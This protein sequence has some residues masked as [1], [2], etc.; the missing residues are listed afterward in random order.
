MRYEKA[1]DQILP[2]LKGINSVVAIFLKG[3]IARDE[4]DEYSDLDLY[5]ML[6]KGIQIEEVYDEVIH[7]LENYQ[8]LLF[9]ELVEIICPQIVGVF[10]DMLH[11]DCY[12]VHEDDYPKTDDIK[13]LYDPNDIL[14]DYK[15]EDLALTPAMFNEVA[16]DSCWFIYQ[17]DHIVKRGQHLWTCQMIDK[18][19]IDTIK[20]LLYRYYPQKAV[21]GKKA[22]HH[23][24][25]GIYYE[26]IAINDLNNSKD[27][28][29]AVSKFMN[30]YRDYVVEIVEEQWVDGFE[31]VYLYLLKKYA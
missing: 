4:N 19:L 27:H 24:P 30:L 10:E 23:L 8:K 21:L 18:A 7:S 26:L 31:K 25:S 11:I 9:Y 1:V 12:L 5:V 3:S 15:T 16:L 20:V 2:K 14:K 6:K 22:A 13:I 28:E 17:Y 29:I